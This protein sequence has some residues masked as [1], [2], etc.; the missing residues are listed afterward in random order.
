MTNFTPE[1]LVLFHYGELDITQ[2]SETSQAIEKNWPLREKYKVI[3]EA[4]SLLD[5]GLKSPRESSVQKVLKYGRRKDRKK[6]L[7]Q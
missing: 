3:E 7:E 6:I 4:A 2:S 5:K 1:Q